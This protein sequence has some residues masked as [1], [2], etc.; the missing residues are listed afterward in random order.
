[1]LADALTSVLA[2][3]ALLAAKYYGVVWM[4]PVMGVLG[5]ILVARWSIGLLKTTSRV[6]LDEQLEPDKFAKIRERLEAG[7]GA[8][9]TDLHVWSIGPGIHA[10]EITIVARE[11]QPP[12]HYR[13][14][15]PSD[16]GIAH[17]TL[18]I[19]PR[20]GGADAKGDETNQDAG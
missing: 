17:V 18:E 20:S 19:H 11:P 14:L 5:S 4:D 8:C 12:D 6:L 1:M 10:A 2:I 9:I 7:G 3:F 15:L 16:L 13:G